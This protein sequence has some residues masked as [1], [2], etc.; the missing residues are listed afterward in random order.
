MPTV[1]ID[2]LCS[3]KRP[4]YSPGIWSPIGFWTRSRISLAAL[5]V[6]VAAGMEAPGTPA[7][8]KLAALRVTQGVLPLPGTSG[9]RYAPPLHETMP[10]CC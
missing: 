8:I 3:H 2:T 5:L 7:S 6:N 4:G 1:I 9:T 10:F